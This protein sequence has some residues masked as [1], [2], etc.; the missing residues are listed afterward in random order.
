M[1][2]ENVYSVL[3]LTMQW[4]LDLSALQSLLQS[5]LQISSQKHGQEYTHVP[6][7][8]MDTYLPEKIGNSVV[9]LSLLDEIS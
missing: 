7:K 5:C 2:A 6:L 4:G 9:I 1:R 3:L 8:M